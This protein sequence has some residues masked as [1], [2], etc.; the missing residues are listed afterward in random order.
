MTDPSERRLR[1]DPRSGDPRVPVDDPTGGR[2]LSR[3]LAVALPVC[4][5]AGLALGIPLAIVAGDWRV[6]IP[7]VLVPA[8]IVGTFLAILEDGRVQRQVDEATRRRT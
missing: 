7:C 5:I 4:A 1:V 6:V 3:R 2:T 8:A